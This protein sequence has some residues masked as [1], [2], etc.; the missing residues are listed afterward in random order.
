MLNVLVVLVVPYVAVTVTAY[1]PGVV[2]PLF[3][4]PQPTV[5]AA[6]TLSSNSTSTCTL[7]FRHLLG[8]Q[9]SKIHASTAP[10]GRVPA[11][12][13]QRPPSFLLKEIVL[14]LPGAFVVI[15]N[16]AVAAFPLVMSTG[17]VEPKLNV[18]G[19]TAPLG[20]LVIA[21]VKVMLP[22]NPA[23]GVIV[24]VSVLFD[25]DPATTFTVDAL[26]RV[27]GAVVDEVTVTD[28]WFVALL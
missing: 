25:P 23:F 19:F 15:V 5:P 11:G 22:E 4:T 21:A 12:T 28:T 10:P 9:I 1:V 8:T 17:L 6:S 20:L 26:L 7:N 13:N 24:I 16:V 2:P 3:S 14:V 18:G 27:N